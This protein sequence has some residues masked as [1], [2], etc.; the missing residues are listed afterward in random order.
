MEI[1]FSD[2]KNLYFLIGIPLLVVAYV[3]N[4][5]YKK[6]AALKFSNFEAISKVFKPAKII[7]YN[8]LAFFVSVIIFV[9]LV[10]AASGATLWY[11]G[12]S[13]NVDFVL[14]IDA[15]ASMTADDFNPDRLASAKNAAI[16]FVDGLPKDA[17]LAVLSFSGT[18]FVEQE[19]NNDFEKAKESIKNIEIKEIGGTDIANALITSTNLMISSSRPKVIVLLTDGRST[20]GVPLEIAIDYVKNAHIIV[21]TIGMGT[22]K[23][24]KI[25][26]SEVISSIDEQSLMEIAYGTEGKYYAAIDEIKLD[27]AYFEI[28]NARKQYISIRLAPLLLSIILFLLIIQW[29]LSFT[30]YNSLP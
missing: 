16:K 4:I 29:I 3:Y 7:T 28:S 8:S 25:V 17:N 10:L 9:C 11:A 2:P 26:G 22:D 21:Y 5:K 20:V 19:L 14:A 6:K 1:T 30:K 24:G 12:K 27:K 23:G 13:T 15:S 18:S